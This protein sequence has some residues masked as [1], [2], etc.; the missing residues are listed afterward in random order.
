MCGSLAQWRDVDRYLVDTLI[1]EDEALQRAREDGHKAAPSLHEVAPN[2]GALL[3]LIVRMTGARRVLEI[4][5]LGGY[6]AIWLG[7][8]VGA[9]GSVT[10]LEVNP[11][12]AAL[13]RRNIERAGLCSTV[14]IVIG[15]ALDSLA[16][17]IEA[18]TAPFD[19]VFID[20]DK[21]NNPR[22]LDAALKLTRSGSVIVADNVVRD[23][24]VIDPDKHRRARARCPR[25][26]RTS[27]TRP[28]ADGRGVRGQEDGA[29]RP[30]LAGA[31][32]TFHRQG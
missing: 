12:Y 24:A 4:G 31:S 8:A 3:G 19:F 13:A 20:A 9:D 29:G 21:P 27:P 1:D 22:Y 14:S 15:P 17:L 10:T 30:H 6:S 26:P 23:G 32:S 5:T 25:L 7:R 11:D 2:Q 28:R 16:E 18:R